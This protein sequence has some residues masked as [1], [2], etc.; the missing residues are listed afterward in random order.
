MIVCV[1]VLGRLCGLCER[2]QFCVANFGVIEVVT[3]LFCVEVLAGE[4]LDDHCVF[5]N[6]SVLLVVSE[7]GWLVTWMRSVRMVCWWLS[8]LVVSSTSLSDVVVLV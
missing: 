6:F 5:V 3:K 4:F 1:G 8:F 7:V 2:G